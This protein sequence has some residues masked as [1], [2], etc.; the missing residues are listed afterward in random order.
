MVQ[1]TV[2]TINMEWIDVNTKLPFL[3]ERVLIYCKSQ[4]IQI[5]YRGNH[6]S[7]PSWMMAF[8]MSKAEL[9]ITHWMKLP[10]FPNS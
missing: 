8:D 2:K 3:G 5:C 4:G 7:K 1:Q 6:N 9:N 10:N